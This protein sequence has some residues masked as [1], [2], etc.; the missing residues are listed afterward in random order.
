MA[1]RKFY[2]GD[3]VKNSKT[4][5]E[6]VI[7]GYTTVHGARAYKGKNAAGKTIVVPETSIVL[8][9]RGPDHK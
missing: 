1:R 5:A 4:D 7:E 9:Q 8:V 3:T 2:I 6:M